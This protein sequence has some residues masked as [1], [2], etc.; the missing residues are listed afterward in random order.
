[1]CK[2][3]SNPRGFNLL[4]AD[5]HGLMCWRGRE[6]A[7]ENGTMS[8]ANHNPTPKTALPGGTRVLNT[9]DGE[10][11]TVLNG[12]ARNTATGEWTEYEVETR[13]GI[14]TWA[15]ADLITMAEANA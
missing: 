1:L 8:T 13:Y 12:V 2:K 3:F 7:T 9:S 6:P 5:P 10:P 11:G 4:N 14:E 15:T